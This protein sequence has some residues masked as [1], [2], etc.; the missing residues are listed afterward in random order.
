MLRQVRCVDFKGLQN[1]RRLFRVAGGFRKRVWY[2]DVD[3]K[4]VKYFP[5]GFHR[6]VIF[7]REALLGCIFLTKML[8]GI[9]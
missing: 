3:F 5:E 1:F 6:V 9:F 2:C 7:L 8:Y 4:R